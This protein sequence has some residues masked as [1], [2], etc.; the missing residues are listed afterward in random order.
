MDGTSFGLSRDATSAA[1]TRNCHCL[2]ST[3]ATIPQRPGGSDDCGYGSHS[4][5]PFGYV[6]RQNS[7]ISARSVTA[8]K[9][10][11][12]GF[13]MQRLFFDDLDLAFGRQAQDREM[14][15]HDV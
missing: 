3:S 11:V 6:R 10:L 15:A 2:H 1:H 7:R 4:Q 9:P 14:L 13:Q 12:G 8:L 5:L